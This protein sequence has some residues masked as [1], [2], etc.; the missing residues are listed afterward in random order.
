MA[1]NGTQLADEIA[2]ALGHPGDVTA[3]VICFGT[4]I[5]THVQS[6]TATFGGFP[7]PHP[8]SGLS[9]PTLA[10]LVGSCAYPFTSPELLTYC[11]IIANY[12]MANGVVTYASPPPNPGAGEIGF[13]EE[14]TISG[15]SGP[16][17]AQL[18]HNALYSVYPGPSTV[19]TA[20]CSAIVGHIQN[21]AEVS[22]GVIS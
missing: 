13:R 22:N 20:K 4:S 18:I 8:I 9:G 14:G 10:G 17:L 1:M 21:N 15:M 12:I 6:G 7:G 3:E 11:T 5:V 2:T 19:L 16:D